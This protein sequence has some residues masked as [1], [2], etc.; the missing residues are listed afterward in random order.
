MKSVEGRHHGTSVC[1][2]YS[3]SVKSSMPLIAP[4]LAFLYRPLGSLSSTTASG[5]S[6]NTSMNARFAFSCNSR[7]IARSA[8]Y[9]DIK[10]VTHI[11]HASANNFDTY[12]SSMHVR[13]R[14]RRYVLRQFYEYFHSLI[15]RRSR[16]P[17]SIQ[18]GCYHRQAGSKTCSYVT[19]VAQVHKQW[20]TT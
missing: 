3:E 20:S 1:M 13:C 14:N 10:A 2:I 8:R 9:G 18:I 12:A 19:D 7:A 15:F 16:D 4:D 6:M 5:A 17:C 11:Q